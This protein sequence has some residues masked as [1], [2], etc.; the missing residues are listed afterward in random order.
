MM[1]CERG[2]VHDVLKLLDFGLVKAVGLDTR[3]DTLTQQGTIAGTP[4]YMSP[5]QAS[6]DEQLDAR[7]D[8]YSLGAVAYFL[9]TGQP[10]FRCDKEIQLILAHIHEPV[11]PITEL[12][13]DVPA[14]LQDVVLRC[15]EKDPARRYSDVTRL[16]EDLAACACAGQ[17]TAGTDA[18]MPARNVSEQPVPNAHGNLLLAAASPTAGIHAVAGKH[19]PTN[20]EKRKRRA[21]PWRFF[22]A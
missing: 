8:V 19:L 3:D 16:H 18:S 1:V 2:G 12:R 15:L 10:P 21:N 20:K 4:A 13:P 11:R 17:W 7:A 6:G 9:L 5:E 14:D 22:C